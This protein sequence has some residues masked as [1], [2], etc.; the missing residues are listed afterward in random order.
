L[1]TSLNHYELHVI[2]CDSQDEI[3]RS[4]VFGLALPYIAFQTA[5]IIFRR[6][7]ERLASLFD[8]SKLDDQVDEI[9][10]ED[11]LRVVNL[12]RPTAERVARQEEARQGLVIVEAQYGE[13]KGDNPAY[14]LP[15]EKV[16]D[17]TI[18]LQAMVADSQ[19]RLYSVTVCFY[20]LNFNC[21][22]V[23]IAGLL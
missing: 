12:M 2:L 3:A 7:L 16:I 20:D 17:V 5:K 19:L 4:V 14:P 22:L 6:P 18:P 1:K 9:K 15:G 23:S 13:M 10:R 11:A 8:D 21:I